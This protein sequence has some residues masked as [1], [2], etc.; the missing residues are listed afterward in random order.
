MMT[1]VMLTKASVLKKISPPH[2]AHSVRQREQF[3]AAVCVDEQDPARRRDV[4]LEGH[5]ARQALRQK[6]TQPMD[7]RN[8][9]PRRGA[10]LVNGNEYISSSISSLY[11]RLSTLLVPTHDALLD[12]LSESTQ[13]AVNSNLWTAKAASCRNY[14]SV[15]HTAGTHSLDLHF[16]VLYA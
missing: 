13:S 8:S 6:R 7:A 10:K 9:A 2:G 15:V 14:A 16:E 5:E 3:V 4:G 1:L 11:L 12:L